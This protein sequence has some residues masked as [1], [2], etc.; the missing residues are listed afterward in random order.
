MRVPDGVGSGNVLIS[1]FPG[2]Q[3]L[4]GLGASMPEGATYRKIVVVTKNGNMI[5]A[6]ENIVW[7]APG[8]MA[9]H[10]TAAEAALLPDT[11]PHQWNI[12]I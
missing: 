11:P 4:F 9:R 1:N 7:V 10:A 6:G 3:P 8:L 12:G 2:N 5:A